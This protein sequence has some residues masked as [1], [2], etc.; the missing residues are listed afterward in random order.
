MMSTTLSDND[1]RE[2]FRLLMEGMRT[3]PDLGARYVDVPFEARR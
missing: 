1:Q 3:D 2:C